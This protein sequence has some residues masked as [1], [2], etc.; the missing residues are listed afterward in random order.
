MSLK[1]EKMSNVDTAWWHMEAPTN[2]MMITTIMVFGG[3]PDYARISA[4]DRRAAAEARSFPPAGRR[5]A[6]PCVGDALGSG[7]NFDVDAHMHRIA[8]PEPG[9]TAALET[10]VSDLMSMPLDYSKPLWQMHIVEGLRGRLRGHRPSSPL[11]RRRHRPD[12]RAAFFDGRERRRRPPI[13]GPCPPAAEAQRG[14]RRLSRPIG[15]PVKGI[16]QDDSSAWPEHG[17]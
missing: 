6:A 2:L 5:S 7:P 17:A 10:L 13:S 14:G 1:S 9:D 15:A 8:L 4:H 11:Y 16:Y 3:R 12:A